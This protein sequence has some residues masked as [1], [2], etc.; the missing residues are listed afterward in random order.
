[1]QEPLDDSLCEEG[2]VCDTRGRY[3]VGPAPPA[4]LR[5]LNVALIGESADQD[6]GGSESYAKAIGEL[7]LADVGSVADLFQHL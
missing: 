3:R 6:I 4:D 2:F 5:R 1:M 7:A